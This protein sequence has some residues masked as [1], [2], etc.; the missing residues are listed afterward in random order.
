MSIVQSSG[1]E[2]PFR[3]CIIVPAL[4]ARATLGAVLDDLARALPELDRAAFFVIDDGSRDDTG[5]IARARGVQVVR[6]EVNRGKGAALV[7]GMRAARER[8][9]P[10]ALTVDADGQHPAS[11]AREVLLA[12]A[13]PRALVLGVRDLAG[14]GAPRANRFSNAISNFFLSRFARRRLADTQCGLRRYPIDET[15]ALGA[16]AT[17]YAFEA[18][19]L[20]RAA[21]AGLPICERPI[22]VVYPPDRE[23]D[24][25]FDSVRDPARIIAAV[26]RALRDTRPA[27]AAASR[28]RR[29]LFVLAAL[30]AAFPAAHLATLVTTRIDA[31]AVNV[32]DKI[33]ASYTR[34]HN[35]IREVY[36]E[37]SP[38]QMG[39]DRERLLRD[40]MVE[41]EAVLWNEFEEMVPLAPARTL[42]LDLGRVRYRHVDRG[43]PETRRRELAAQAR[44]FQPDPFDDKLST[45][46]RMVFLQALYDIALGFENAPLVG[47][48]AMALGPGATKDGHT[49]V[50]RAF[51]FEASDILETDKTVYFV[52]GEGTIPFASVAWPGLVGV[53]TGMN[54]EGV[55]VLVNG[56]R[57]REPRAEGMPIVFAL[58]EVL[59]RA[60]TTSEAVAVLRAQEVMVSH[61]VLV[62]DASGKL[63]VVERAP[64]EVPTVR[65][66]WADP[67]RVALTNHFEGPLAADPKNQRVRAESTTLARRA[68]ADEL[69]RAV[70]AREADVPRAVTM[71]RDHA[72]AGG[73]ACELGDR[74]TV[75]ALIA[76]H[77]VVADTT[78][79]V[80]WV[81]AGP[82]LSGPFVRFDLGEV[83]GWRASPRGPSTEDAPIPADP[84]LF[85]GRYDQ[86]RARAGKPRFKGAR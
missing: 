47:C 36:L 11:S 2:L 44:A 56:A 65:D 46:H 50:A 18:E 70:G 51:D 20:L 40:R 66:A 60:T 49:L 32:P 76:T 86:G 31:P 13:S 59:E 6:H 80:L 23:R 69:V 64:G 3:A 19:V 71:L 79:R 75:D 17:G 14:A 45:Y 9:F 10:V 43:V 21:R 34:I 29:A 74:R 84:L 39:A 54:L 12:D 30:A 58:R 55:M 35:G 77:G 27:P 5:E 37:G 7:S 85:D 63:A 16:R 42:L 83:F 82:H 73:G 28:R 48:T 53:V 25:H 15:L 61:L 8:G 24:T 67:D 1:P 26:L 22:R 68:R 62:A 57:A 4:D 78:A 72:C 38:E 41:D 52:R 33:A 81:G